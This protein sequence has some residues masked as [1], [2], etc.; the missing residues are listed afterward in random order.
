AGTKLIWVDADFLEEA[1]ETAESIPLWPG[2]DPERDI[3]TADPSRAYAAGLSPRPISQTIAEIHAAELA[4]PT[5]S[6]PGT[7]LSGAREAELLT[8]GPATKPPPR[9]EI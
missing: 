5:P 3:N 8:G 4:A 2:G 6:R 7:G 9:A 1:G